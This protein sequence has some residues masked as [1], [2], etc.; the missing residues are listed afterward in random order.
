MRIILVGLL[1]FFL[2]V[3]NTCVRNSWIYQKIG[4]S[5]E[6]KV[7]AKV[8][9]KALQ[10]YISTAKTSNRDSIEAK[11]WYLLRAFEKERG[12][13]IQKKTVKL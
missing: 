13:V 10:V 3:G 4:L 8:H 12:E 9:N 2:A 7:I 5:L 1:I 11:C 6:D